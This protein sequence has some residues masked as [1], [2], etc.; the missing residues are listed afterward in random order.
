MT[1]YRPRERIVNGLRMWIDGSADY[2]TST[3]GLDVFTL[4]QHW[5]TA[6]Q[7]FY[8]GDQSL[9]RTMVRPAGD[10]HIEACAHTATGWASIV[11]SRRHLEAGLI[12]SGHA[13]MLQVAA[14]Y[15]VSEHNCDADVVV[16]S[17]ASFLHDDP[18]D[19]TERYAPPR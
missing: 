5:R 18:R 8:A 6:H 13:V 7:A 17:V 16:Q 15:G 3:G 19:Q 14:D 2:V 11:C 1:I 4:E 10:G 9:C 12:C